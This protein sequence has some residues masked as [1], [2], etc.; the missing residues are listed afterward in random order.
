M[1]DGALSGILSNMQG[2]E[3][4]IFLVGAPRSG[5]SLLGRIVGLSPDVAMFEETGLISLVYARMN[6]IKVR[7][8]KRAGTFIPSPFDLWVRHACD[9]LRGIDRLRYLLRRML[10]YT[11]I[12]DYDLCPGNGL[13]DI[14]NI[15]LDRYDEKLLDHLY[16]KYKSLMGHDFGSVA[17]V[18]LRDYR[19]LAEKDRIAEK[20]PMHFLYLSLIFERFPRTKVV[21]I[22]RNKKD[23]LVSYVRTFARRHMSWRHAIR[24]IHRL[25]EQAHIV[26]ADYRDHPGVLA[27]AYED[28]LTDSLATVRRIYSFLEVAPPSD[29][30]AKL[31]GVRQTPSRWDKLTSK[32][33]RCIRRLT[34]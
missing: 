34:K 22:S 4:P 8:L 33:Q 7:G 24:H 15:R 27:V 10:E 1:H 23:V 6:P 18:L 13:R 19:M 26:A 9:R 5:T 14:Q 30:D 29:L 12:R 3:S 21:F 17:G 28:L 25:Y 31:Q 16:H 2:E 32:Q 20:T 11:R